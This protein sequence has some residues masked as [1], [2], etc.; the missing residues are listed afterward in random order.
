M[1]IKDKTYLTL[2][3]VPHQSDRT[4]TLRLPTW[5]AKTL[6]ACVVFMLLGLVGVTTGYVGKFVD[7]SLLQ[8]LKLENRI[9]RD[10]ISEF[11]TTL[12]GLQGQINDFVNFDSK[13]RMM[14]GLP[15]IDPDVRRVGVGGFTPA[16]LPD[17]ITPGT[18]ASLQTVQQ[19]LEKLDREARLQ[20]ESFE[21]IVSALNEKQ[22]MWDHLPS[23]QP[24]PGWIISAFG[25]RR[26]PLAGDLRMHEG[27]DI[28][29]PD[30]AII[31]APAAGTVKFVGYR[32]NYG[33]CLELDHGYGITTRY[34]HCSMVKVSVGQKVNRGQVVALVG[35]TG[36]V[37]GPH[38]HYEVSV[39]GQPKDPTTYILSARMF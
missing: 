8:T 1:A 2:I 4:V 36:R 19:D 24:T 9:L 12:D 27:I 37:T 6:A 3:I 31:A 25:V 33:L 28:A 34:A 16:P 5:L 30:G 15:P 21:A 26:D 20:L 35:Q 32:N 22:E 38:L 17:G 13:V 29:G 10:K 39:N 18:A 11:G 7:A 14:S 23:I